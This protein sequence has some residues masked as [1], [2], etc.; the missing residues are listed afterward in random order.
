MTKKICPNPSKLQILKK[1]DIFQ[2]WSLKTFKA[3]LK[4]KKQ[5]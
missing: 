3:N 2:I 5:Q 4:Q 1:Q